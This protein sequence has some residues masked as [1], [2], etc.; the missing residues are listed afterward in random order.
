MMWSLQA[1]RG[2]AVEKDQHAEDREEDQTGASHPKSRTAYPFASRARTAGKGLMVASR[3]TMSNVPAG[4]VQVITLEIL[5]PVASTRLITSET[6]T[7]DPAPGTIT[8]TRLEGSSAPMA[9]LRSR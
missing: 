7:A 4:I 5:M 1:H 3:I 9:W 8:S 6:E 2:H